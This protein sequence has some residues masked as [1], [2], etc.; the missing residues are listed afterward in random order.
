MFWRGVVGY[1]PVNLVQLVAGFGS[2][3]VFTRLLT[4]AD[5]G[6]YALGF[7][8]STLVQSSLL[9]W[10]EAAMARF[11][12]AEREGADRAAL[13]ATVYRTFGVLAA[14]V[15]LVALAAMA[16]MPLSSGVRLALGAGVLA[17]VARSGLKLAQERRRAAGAVRGFAVFD[18]VQT[19]GGFLLGVGAVALG[20]RGAGPLIGA[21]A[22]SAVCLA[23][24]LPA[25]LRQARGGRF[26]R[27]RFARYA[28]YGLPVSLSLVMSLALATTDRFVLA[29][30]RDAATV[31]AYHAGYSLSN[32]T[33][34]VLFIWLGMAGGPAAI[35]ALETGG[36]A[37]LRKVAR[38]QAELMVLI[39]LPAATGL[40][41]VARPLADLMVGPA[42]RADAARV[43]PWIAAGGLCAGLTTYY[44]HTAFTLARRTRSLLVAWMLPAAINL[45]LTLWLIP[46][47]GLDG[48]MWATTASYAIGLVAS[49]V[50]GRRHLKLPV[51]WTT[52]GRAALAS[53]LMAG[54]LSLLPSPGGALELGVKATIGALVYGA[55]VLVMNAGGV[56]G[57]LARG[58]LAA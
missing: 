11:Y 33:L 38:S 23:F 22:A 15:P 56:R 3:W 32:R 28:A 12:A 37:A 9:V 53:A 26:D 35:A 41:L 10:N 27:S 45:G 42:L 2:I 16:A 31:G 44:L 13:F 21:G 14:V 58:G 47:Y 17:V 8:V 51:P 54:A 30:A 18:M 52:L 49:F 36:E 43:T 24:A 5:Y 25:E 48:A 29:G 39:A 1:L 6:D 7:S 40:A 34:D 57:L 46:R 20:A 19:G 4:P 55:A 50:L